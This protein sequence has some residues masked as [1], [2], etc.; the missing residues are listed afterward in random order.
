MLFVKKITRRK[1]TTA[2]NLKPTKLQ[3]TT[4]PTPYTNIYYAQLLELATFKVPFT[5]TY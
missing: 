3:T 1:H 4:I 2:E 5:T